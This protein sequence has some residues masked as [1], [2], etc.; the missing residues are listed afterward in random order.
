MHISWNALGFAVSC[1]TDGTADHC[2][3]L[4]LCL[5]PVL[6]ASGP[7]TQARRARVCIDRTMPLSVPC[8]ESVDSAEDRA[9]SCVVDVVRPC[10]RAA[11]RSNRGE[12][13]R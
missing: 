9:P 5:V 4:S 2:Q 13:L 8:N 12:Y 7:L 3:R 10:T 11:I 1:G 6:V